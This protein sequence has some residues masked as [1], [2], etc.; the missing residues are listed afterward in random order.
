MP[1]RPF[2]KFP[3]EKKKRDTLK[4]L[5]F[6]SIHDSSTLEPYHLTGLCI[7]IY[8]SNH[9]QIGEKG[10]HHKNSNHISSDEHGCCTTHKS[11]IASHG[12][13]DQ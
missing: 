13:F 5:G 7:H 9:V 2:G 3:Q 4:N 1:F 12:K 6:L 10:C 11:Q 8:Y